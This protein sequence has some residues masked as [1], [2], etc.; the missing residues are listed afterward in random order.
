MS[1]PNLHQI[2]EMLNK[3]WMTHDAM[4]FAFCLQEVGIETTNRINLR[5]VRAMA[6]IEVK[7]LMKLLGMAQVHDFEQLRSFVDGAAQ[8]IVADFMGFTYSFHSPDVMRCNM[9]KCFAY[10]GITR[11]GVIKHYQC[12]IFE[13]VQGWLDALGVAY[14]VEP[15]VERCMMFSQGQCHREYRI[16]GF[17][18]LA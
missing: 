9:G 1:D 12:G 13:R 8:I 6:Q 3:Q 7:R 10:D 4:W 11:L 15:K 14:E 16:T 17:S 5:A 2:K 18:G